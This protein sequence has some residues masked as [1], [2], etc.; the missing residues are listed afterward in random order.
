MPTTFE[1]VAITTTG[2]NAASASAPTT[3]M[4]A[5][6]RRRDARPPGSASSSGAIAATANAAGALL[7]TAHTA[8][9]A[10]TASQPAARRAL[11][12]APRQ[13]A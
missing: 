7:H 5:I 12:P 10:A 6:A 4:P 2:T 3:A 9:T 11:V 13:R 8:A 1:R